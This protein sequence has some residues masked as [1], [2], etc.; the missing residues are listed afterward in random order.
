VIVSCATAGNSRR[1]IK[2][3]LNVKINR[4]IFIFKNT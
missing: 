3:M 2:K 1:T 4:L